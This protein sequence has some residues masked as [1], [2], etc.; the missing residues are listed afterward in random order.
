[1]TGENLIAFLFFWGI[2]L[3]V[4]MIVDGTGVLTQLV[5]V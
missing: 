3:L 4:P 5:G 1:M 2:W